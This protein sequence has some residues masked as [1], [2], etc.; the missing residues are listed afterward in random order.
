MIDSTQSFVD[1]SIAGSESSSQLSGVATI[2]LQ[3]SDPPSGNA[4]ITDLSLAFDES[5]S[6][7]FLL[8]L[9]T[10]STSPGDVTISLVTPGDPGTIADASF[11]Q[12][13]NLLTLDGN[14]NVSDPFG[15]AGGN[16]TVDLSTLEVTPIDF[17]SISVTQSDNV[18]TVSSSFRLAE[19]LDFGAGPVM[20]EVD[21]SF[22][23]SGILAAP[24]LLG[25]VNTDDVVDFLDISPFVA[26]LTTGEFQAEADIDGNGEIDFLDIA[27][28]VE[29]LSSQ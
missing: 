10:A 28:F 20:I 23:A 27:P 11:D 29:L 21:G 9:V 12:L 5:L 8:G 14:L 1:I 2:D 15:F 25:D 26:L 7:S 16:Q 4:Q 17:N 22:V 3:F 18:I 13:A 6:A 19:T 24:V